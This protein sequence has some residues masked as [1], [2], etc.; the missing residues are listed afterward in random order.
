[1]SEVNETPDWQYAAMRFIAPG[2]NH[3]LEQI[4][5]TLCNLTLH[6]ADVPPQSLNYKEPA[7][8]NAIR[9][10]VKAVADA[11]RSPELEAAEQRLQD[12]QRTIA[13]LEQELAD[14]RND[15]VNAL[16]Q[17]KDSATKEK[18]VRDLQSQIDVVKERLPVLESLVKQHD[19]ALAQKA[20]EAAIA[21]VDHLEAKA[22]EAFD[23]LKNEFDAAV[24]ERLWPLWEAWTRYS[25]L[26]LEGRQ[27]ALNGRYDDPKR[28]YL[29]S[30]HKA[31]S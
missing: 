24:S 11:V 14:T 13:R 6:A 15:I 31:K 10:E 21:H 7:V 2:R 23:R 1:M 3:R 22:K 4:P 18:K 29:E 8:Y 26:H 16:R 12:T 27:A 30:L 9:D 19:D 17:G 5:G 20:N 28:P 25:M